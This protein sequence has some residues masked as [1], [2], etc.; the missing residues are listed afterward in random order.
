M[1]IAVGRV[2]LVDLVEQVFELQVEFLSPIRR[3]DSRTRRTNE[4]QIVVSTLVGG[5][6]SLMSPK[7]SCGNPREDMGERA[8]PI[9]ANSRDSKLL[10]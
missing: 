7:L 3:S 5:S 8:T 9:T 2:V 4:S 10:L 6:N 1:M